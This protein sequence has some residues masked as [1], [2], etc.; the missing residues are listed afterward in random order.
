MECVRCLKLFSTTISVTPTCP[1][2]IPAGLA[3]SMVLC[4]PKQ[5]PLATCGYLNLNGLQL[6]QIK[7]P[8]PSGFTGHMCFVAIMLGCTNTE[9][10]HHLRKFCWTAASIYYLITR[11]YTLYAYSPIQNCWPH[12]CHPSVWHKT[13]P[14]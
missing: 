14:R 7:Y 4:S 11:D 2:P 8:S 6:N 10:F 3:P 1:L 9:H 5:Q 12:C 13:G